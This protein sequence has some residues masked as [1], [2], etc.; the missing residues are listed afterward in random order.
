MRLADVMILQCDYREGLSR[1]EAQSVDLVLTDPPYGTTS[2]KWDQA[3]DLREFWELVN[4]S[5]KDN[6]VVVSFCAQPFTTDLI[7]SNRRHFRYELIWHK[8]MAVGFLD[9][10][11]RPMR[12]HENLAV[13]CRKPGGSTYNPQMTE[14][15]PYKKSAGPGKPAVH[16]NGKRRTGGRDN[17]G[18]RYPRSVM[19]H[20]NRQKPSLHPTQKP[21]DLVEWLVKTYSNEGDL[22]ADP[23]MGSG[24]TL[25]AAARNRR[26][27]VGIEREEEYA[28]KAAARLGLEAA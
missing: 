1:L 7:N 12:A 18:T 3:P 6:G 8:T 13:F 17:A 27:A 10:K 16:Y 15:K 24:T 23:F 28:L 20:N 4:Y 19:T 21:L 14:G 25:V 11:K 26:R 22:V 2:I 5:L 9:A